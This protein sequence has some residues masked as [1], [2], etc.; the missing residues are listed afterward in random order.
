MKSVNWTVRNITLQGR[1]WMHNSPSAVKYCISFCELHTAK[2][3][4]ST[5]VLIKNCVLIWIV[6]CQMYK[7]MTRVQEFSPRVMSESKLQRQFH[8]IG[9]GMMKLKITKDAITRITRPNLA[10]FFFFFSL[11]LFPLLY[12]PITETLMVIK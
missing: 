5:V 2:V 7:V 3:L 11:M 8:R 10:S 1:A 6:L 12:C 4:A 9:L